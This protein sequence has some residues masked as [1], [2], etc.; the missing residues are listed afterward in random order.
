[1]EI[2]FFQ[3][4]HSKSCLPAWFGRFQYSTNT[5]VSRFYDCSHTDTW[6]TDKCYF[7]PRTTATGAIWTLQASYYERHLNFSTRCFY[8]KN[9]LESQI[10]MAIVS[11]SS[12]DFGRFFNLLL[13]F[14][15]SFQF[16]RATFVHTQ[17]CTVLTPRTQQLTI[18]DNQLVKL[19]DVF[20]RQ[21][22]KGKLATGVCKNRW[23]FHW[24]LSGF[25]FDFG[26]FQWPFFPKIT[27]S[28]EPISGRKRSKT[29]VS[30][31]SELQLHSLN[32]HQNY[33]DCL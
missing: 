30:S 22:K 25:S 7:P 11:S 15:W 2:H 19:A 21:N 31:L 29:V 4:R 10:Y 9:V 28:P 8:G 26:K 13:I 33:S 3:P 1:M 24:S 5:R 14:F 27:I 23:V 17:H 16:F 32:L 12:D 18:V 6:H 20:L